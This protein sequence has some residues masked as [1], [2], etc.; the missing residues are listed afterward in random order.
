MLS[1]TRQ[2]SSSLWQ[3][4]NQIF[5]VA[6]P[7]GNH[8]LKILQ[9]LYYTLLA[10]SGKIHTIVLVSKSIE[11][12]FTRSQSN[13]FVTQAC[14]FNTFEIVSFYVY[15][16]SLIL[17]YNNLL[18]IFLPVCLFNLF[19]VVKTS[20]D[21][22]EKISPG[23]STLPVLMRKLRGKI[24]NCGKTLLFLVSRGRLITK[25]E[26]RKGSHRSNILHIKHFASRFSQFA[27]RTFSFCKS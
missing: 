3:T 11:V 19:S 2:K 14:N 27:N 21:A 25:D 7:N 4:L 23:C 12:I 20:T 26:K 24:R 13:K 9:G 6:C 22:L 10:V 15:Q 5:Y 8:F 16:I 17:Q 1:R 18:Q